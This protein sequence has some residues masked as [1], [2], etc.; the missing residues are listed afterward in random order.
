MG[1]LVWHV[2]GGKIYIGPHWYCSVIMLSFILGVGSYYSSSAAQAGLLQLLGG[3]VVT[4]LSTITFLR[5]ALANPGVLRAKARAVE[6]G[7]M[8]R[9]CEACNVVQPRGCSHC[10]FCQA[11]VEGFDHH[12]PWMGKCIGRQNLC[13]FYTFICVS[14]SS[15]GYIFVCTILQTVPSSAGTLRN[16]A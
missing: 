11:C 16:A 12:C 3:V 1:I 7:A 14:F 15:L 13:A 4:S 2:P 5:C 10:D 6:D 8:G 9:R